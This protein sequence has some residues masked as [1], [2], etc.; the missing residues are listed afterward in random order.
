MRAAK[1]IAIVTALLVVTTSCGKI[2]KTPKASSITH[3]TLQATIAADNALGQQIVL[4]SGDLP[5]GWVEQSVAPLSASALAV[6]KQSAKLLDTC[7]NL[8]PSENS[9]Y[10][11]VSGSVFKNGS[12][13]IGSAVSFF[14]SS[15]TFSQYFAGVQDPTHANCLANVLNASYVQSLKVKLKNENVVVNSTLS[16]I[17]GFGVGK[18]AYALRVTTDV[19]SPA[20][21][22]VTT[23]TIGFAKGNAIVAMTFRYPGSLPPLDLEQ[24]LL[25]KLLSHTNAFVKN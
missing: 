20:P 10:A 15:S 22:T 4:V 1:N 23:D 9:F 17:P 6:A 12:D 13:T 19:V 8:P 16:L 24:S 25:S 11:L 2:T 18:E 3:S 14:R 5:T 7:I 21:L